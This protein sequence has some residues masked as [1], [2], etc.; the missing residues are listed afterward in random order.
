MDDDSIFY[1]HLVQFM[2][3]SYILWP[4]GIVRGIWYIF[5]R[6]GILYQEKSENPGT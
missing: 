5:P 2:V 6:F 1:G 4:F 3:F